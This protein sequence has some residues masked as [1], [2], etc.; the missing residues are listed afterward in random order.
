MGAVG[1]IE[2]TGQIRVVIIFCFIL[3]TP[4]TQNAEIGNSDIRSVPFV[5]KSKTIQDPTIL[6]KPPIQ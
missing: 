3:M 5:V 2:I 6:A 4:P 1:T